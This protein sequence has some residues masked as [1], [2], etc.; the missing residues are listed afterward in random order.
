MLIEKSDWLIKNQR[1]V[2]IVQPPRSTV[3]FKS[4]STTSVIKVLELYCMWTATKHNTIA[5][6]I[7]R[8]FLGCRLYYSTVRT[9]YAHNPPV[10]YMTST[11]KSYCGS[12]HFSWICAANMYSLNRDH[13]VYSP[14]QWETMSHCDD[15]SHW[16]GA[17]AKWSLLIDLLCCQNTCSI[18]VSFS[19]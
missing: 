4:I 2:F 6:F 14:S 13:A 10:Y 9:I 3:N 1:T 11:N 8:Y 12:I 15:V 5:W 18:I 16:L 17:Y 19:T 7:V